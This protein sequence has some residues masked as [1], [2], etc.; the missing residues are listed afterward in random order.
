MYSLNF[1]T[2]SHEAA[3]RSKEFRVLSF[4]WMEFLEFVE[5][6][7]FYIT[8]SAFCTRLHSAFIVPTSDFSSCPFV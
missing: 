8:H 4:E 2:K 7:E 6:I 3:R 5:F 1:S